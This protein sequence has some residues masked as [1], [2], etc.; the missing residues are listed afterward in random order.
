MALERYVKRKL[1]EELEVEG[2]VFIENVAGPGVPPDFPDTTALSPSGYTCHIEWKKSKSAT[3][4]AG[5]LWWNRELNKHNHRAF[6][7]YPENWEEVKNAIIRESR[8]F[9][10]RIG[11]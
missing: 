9:L 5:Q 8:E 4:R 1:K 3:V 11:R 7:V 10:K 2:W 6:I